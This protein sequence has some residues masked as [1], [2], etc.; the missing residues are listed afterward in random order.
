MD[1]LSVKG[2]AFAPRGKTPLA[3]FLAQDLPELGVQGRAPRLPVAPE[4]SA[5]AP[6]VSA[7]AASAAAGAASA[8]VT[9]K[10]SGCGGCAVPAPGGASEAGLLWLLGAAALRRRR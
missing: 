4:S 3:D 7:P 2:V 10:K 6:A 5:S 8:G 9:E 1:A